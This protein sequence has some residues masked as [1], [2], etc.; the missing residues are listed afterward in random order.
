M[1]EVA[2]PQ[3]QVAPERCQV[4]CQAGLPHDQPPHVMR[5]L[6]AAACELSVHCRVFS[7]YSVL[8]VGFSQ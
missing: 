3:E 8:S 6:Q 1:V 4:R 7:A 2:L 5:C